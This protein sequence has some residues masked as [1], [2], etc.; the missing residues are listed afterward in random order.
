MPPQPPIRERVVKSFLDYV[1]A[2]LDDANQADP[3]G[4]YRGE[5]RT[6]WRLRPSGARPPFTPSMAVGMANAFRMKAPTVYHGSSPADGDEAGWL[7]LMQHYRLPTLLL[8]W[9]TSP[10]IAAF[11]VLEDQHLAEDGLVWRLSPDVLNQHIANLPGILALDHPAMQRLRWASL[12]GTP[13]PDSVLAT[14]PVEIDR[15]MVV[16]H[17]AFT[18]HGDA[19]PLDERQDAAYFLLRIVIPASVKKELRLGLMHFGIDRAS[20]FPDLEN[21][22]RHLAEGHALGHL[23]T[24]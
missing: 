17:S 24:P 14:M 16:Q 22:A 2:C 1:K 23:V 21:L 10:L 3:L 5:S 18:A 11:F 13:V 20:L 4:W 7:S 6:T 15:R 19:T 9:S 12:T 8:D